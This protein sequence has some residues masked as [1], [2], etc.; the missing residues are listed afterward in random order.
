[1]GSLLKNMLILCGLEC[2][3][4]FLSQINILF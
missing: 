2:A 3:N 1:M 4:K